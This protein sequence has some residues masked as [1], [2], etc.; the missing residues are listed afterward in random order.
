MHCRLSDSATAPRDP[1]CGI[2]CLI[3]QRF[4]PHPAACEKARKPQGLRANLSSRIAAVA[5][6]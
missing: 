3:K 6:T 1:L 4:F 2:D 5:K